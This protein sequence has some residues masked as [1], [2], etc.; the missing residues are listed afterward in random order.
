M[1]RARRRE[2]IGNGLRP[3]AKITGQIA[4]IAHLVPALAAPL[5]GFND[6]DEVDQLAAPDAIGHGMLARPRPNHR[7]MRQVRRD[8]GRDS[9]PPRTTFGP[10]GKAERLN[11]ANP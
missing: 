11:C 4:R 6:A 7:R 8:I 3:S 5:I 10:F 9:D 1:A 2:D